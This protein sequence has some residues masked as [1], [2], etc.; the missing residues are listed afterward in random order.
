VLECL[1]FDFLNFT[2]GRLDPSYDAIARK[3]GLGRSTVAVALARLKALGIVHW[4]RRCAE[5]WDVAKGFLLR[6]QTNAYGVLPPSQWNG[7]DAAAE[8]PPP[9]PTAWGASPPLPPLIEQAR[10]TMHTRAPNAVLAL[11]EQDP[12][13][14][15]AAALARLGRALQPQTQLF[16]GVQITD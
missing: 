14:P 6:Q 16:T 11:L 15:L 9:D 8:P 1:L 3:T 2:S 7:C 4:V 13:D 12:K 10:A 5:S